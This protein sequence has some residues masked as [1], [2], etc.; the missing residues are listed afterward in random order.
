MK[1]YLQKIENKIFCFKPVFMPIRSILIS[2]SSVLKYFTYEWVKTAQSCL[3]LCDPMDDTVHRILQARILEWVDIPFSRWFSQPKDRTQVSRT[4]GRFFTNWAT[5]VT[6]LYLLRI[7]I[8]SNKSLDRNFFFHIHIHITEWDF[9]I[10]EIYS[11]N[12]KEPHGLNLLSS[13]NGGILA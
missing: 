7:S 8:L 11:E 6:L 9:L 1:A 13:I 10:Q 3:T 5:R 12:S 2:F 4:A